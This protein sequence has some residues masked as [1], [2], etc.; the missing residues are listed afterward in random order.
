MM[1]GTVTTSIPQILLMAN[2]LL[3][4][5]LAGKVR[6]LWKHRIFW[7]LSSVFLIHLT[8]LLWTS[9]LGAGGFDVRTKMPLM[10]LPLLLLSSK[11]FEVKEYRMMLACFLAGCAD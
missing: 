6:S 1:V 3:E 9:D 11:P 2:W 4:P 10:F 8:G 5:G 7:V